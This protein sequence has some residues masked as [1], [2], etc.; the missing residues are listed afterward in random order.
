MTRSSTGENVY[1]RI[2][3]GEHPR[4][5]SW[6]GTHEVGDGGDLRRADDVVAFTPMLGLSGVSGK[7]WP[8]I[9]LVVIPTLLFSLLQSKF[10]LPAHLALLAPDRPVAQG[11]HRCSG[12]SGRSRTGWS[13]SSSGSTSRRWRSRLRWRYVLAAVVP[14]GPGVHRWR[15]WPAGWIKSQFFPEVEGDI[16]SAKFELALGA[17]RS[18]KPSGWSSRSKRRPGGWAMNFRDHGRR[19]GGAAH[20]DERRAPSRSRPDSSPAGRRRP[21]TSAR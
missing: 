16:L 10:V 15:W 20:A 19:S 21:P 17:C 7:I 5:A 4:E 9:P 14:R 12:C 2:Q 1:T 11:E 3:R 13:G 8:N 18:R 6:K